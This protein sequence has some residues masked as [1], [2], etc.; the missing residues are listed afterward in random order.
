[1]TPQQ[2]NY[3]ELVFAMID[4]NISPVYITSY[5]YHETCNFEMKTYV[6]WLL[7]RWILLRNNIDHY[8]TQIKHQKLLVKK[9]R[10]NID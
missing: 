7:N 1:M 10:F 4:R 2:L 5:M 3:C 9:V 6:D 8:P